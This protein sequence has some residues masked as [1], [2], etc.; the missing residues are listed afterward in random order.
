MRLFLQFIFACTSCFIGAYFSMGQSIEEWDV[1]FREGNLDE[2]IE[3]LYHLYFLQE[4]ADVDDAFSYAQHV[5]ELGIQ[6]GREDA[7]A[8]A[9]YCHGHYLSSKMLLEE[10]LLRFEAA[11][12]TFYALQN[13]TLCSEVYNGIG[14]AYFLK[15]D[16]SSA[17]EYYL[18]SIDL[19]RTSD[20]ERFQL[21]AYPNLARIYRIQNNYVEAE[22]LLQE[23]INFYE[24]TGKLTKLGNAY[25]ILGQLYLDQEK[26]ETAMEYLQKGLEFQ[27]ALGSL[28]ATANG[29]TNLAIANFLKGDVA[30][31]E[32]DF[33]TALKY[34]LQEGNPFFLA[35]AYFN[36]GDFYIE[37]EELDSTIHYYLMS[38]S[39]AE[40]S[41]NLIGSSDACKRLAEAYERVGN[42]SKQLEY[43]KKY[44]ALQ[45][46]QTL[47]TTSKQLNLLR[48][49]FEWSKLEQE[50][51]NRSRE[52]EM[53]ADLTYFEHAWVRWRWIMVAI[54]S[55]LGIIFI[56][57]RRTT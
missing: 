10:S 29:Y 9:N 2:K 15:G 11:F 40:Q 32:R 57:K 8:M 7:L 12:S 21:I 1:R 4:E 17:E 36:M 22:V 23:Y 30:Q 50:Q 5:H 16:Y 52:Q 6:E 35:E 14:N 24:E 26:V 33:R 3:A 56:V 31:A 20:A 18:R 53:Q 38:L 13:D 39:I 28:R 51:R 47:Q 54:V 41:T 44:I 34:R 48:E 46:E 55:A 42:I 27:L 37:Q 25:G 49:S 19:A 43:L 45:E